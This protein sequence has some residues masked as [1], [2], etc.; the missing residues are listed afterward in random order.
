[1]ARKDEDL[2]L[3]EL[4]SVFFDD[5]NEQTEAPKAVAAQ[6]AAT[7]AV[8]N[9]EED[10]DSV[11]GQLA[12]DVYETT[13]RLIIKARTAG[14]NKNELDVSIADGVL[15]ISFNKIQQE[16]AKKIQVL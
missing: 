12:V 9:T 6:T 8:A 16:A 15:T 2:L 3:D 14:V 4:D 7:P 1:M 10:Y 11:P 13:D 5:N